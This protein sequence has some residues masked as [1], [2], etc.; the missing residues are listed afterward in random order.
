MTSSSGLDSSLLDVESLHEK[1]RASEEKISE[2]VS[3]RSRLESDIAFLRQQDE[4]QRLESNV[5]GAI[6][7]V[8]FFSE[9]NSL[10]HGG[11][12][13]DG[14][15]TRAQLDL[16][17]KFWQADR[18]LEVRLLND[19]MRSSLQALEARTINSERLAAQLKAESNETKNRGSMIPSYY[20]LNMEELAK[21][22]QEQREENIRLRTQLSKEA[23][24]T[25]RQ[26]AALSEKV[27]QLRER[28]VVISDEE[29]MFRGS[30]NTLRLNL[31]EEEAQYEKLCK[32]HN[33]LH[34]DIFPLASSQESTAASSSSWVE[35]AYFA[36]AGNLQKR[37]HVSEVVS[38]VAPWVA[39][40][41]QLLAIL[42]EGSV[43]GSSAH[44][45]SL[46][47]QAGD[48]Q[49]QGP[50]VPHCVSSFL[51]KT[52]TVLSK[53]GYFDFSVFVSFVS[54]LG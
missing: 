42:L 27:Q 44:Q 17:R 3:E 33:E 1:I 13:G 7:K 11:K 43:E 53:P 22:A 20:L 26:R 48:T 40:S 29:W 41:P 38:C 12:S 24:R 30:A 16:D 28:L 10:K 34:R 37:L 2:L 49:S 50:T 9:K 4:A 5:V 32:V 54:W 19:D 45:G 23:D 39:T 25:A 15:M 6:D 47:D 18:K 21:A 52:G 31:C 36:S 35:E 46:S 8:R 51:K 14:G